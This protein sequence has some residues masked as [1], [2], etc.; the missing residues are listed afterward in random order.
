MKTIL[1]PWKVSSLDEKDY[2]LL[3]RQF[4]LKSFEFNLINSPVF[5]RRKLII[6]HDNFDAW[7]KSAKKNK[8]VALVSGFMTSGKFHVGS[9][10]VLR[11]MAYYQERYNARL[12]IPIADL[13]AICVRKTDEREVKKVLVEF[14]AHF[15]AA[16]IDINKCDIYL[17][18]R[19]LDVLRQASIFTKHFKNKDFKRVYSRD[20][21]IGEAFSSLV[22]VSDIL[23]PQLLGYKNTLITLG[24]DEI[25]HFILVKEI[26]KKINSNFIF[27][28]ITYHKL[29]T[30]LTGS[31]MG[32]SIPENS[33]LLTDSLKAAEDKLASLR[34]KN[35]P[36]AK[37]AAFNILQ[38]YCTNDFIIEK[39]LAEKNEK[40]RNNLAIDYAIRTIIGILG[41]HQEKYKKFLNKAEKMAS[42]LYE[43]G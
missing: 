5:A 27:P 26:V 40:E 39:I 35:L 30:G 14:L 13:E 43:N 42:N 25:N 28:S 10:V 11:Q 21:T 24:I 3:K 20:L 38:W 19:N 37:N 15:H 18:S 29:I 9:L 23:Y 2:H 17:Q 6:G 16:G 4:R 36:L 22:M 7:L 12:F 8:K 33:I 41:N 31:K 32:K 34:D 1:N